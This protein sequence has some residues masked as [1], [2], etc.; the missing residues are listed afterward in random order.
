MKLLD[1]KLAP[2]PRRV[3]IFAAEK[4]IDLP[5][6]EID[7]MAAENRQA[8]FLERNP[9]AGVPVLILD[10][11]TWL[12]ETVAICRYLEEECPEPPLFGVD[13]K[14]RAL[15]EMWSRRME[16]EIFLNCAG[17]F[18]NSHEFFKGRIPQVPEYGAVCKEAAFERLRW[19]DGELAD[20]E[21]IAGERFTIADIT[22]V[23]GIDF[24][25]V[26][27]IKL[28]DEHPNLK[29]WHAAVAARPS[30]GA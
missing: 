14:D 11:G 16:F 10:D 17:P 9:M 1:S 21:W 15:V 6:Q 19:L 30:Y 2:N 27:G 28:S 23:C 25:R 20:R 4:G 7:I 12:S 5:K 3:R 26:S 22:A 8:P 13:Q 24:G 29:R 18:R